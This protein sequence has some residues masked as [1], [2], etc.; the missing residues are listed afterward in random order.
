MK[1][2]DVLRSL[3][4]L[5]H[6]SDAKVVEIADLAGSVTTK[7]EVSSY[8][9]HE[10]EPGFV[11]CPDEFLALF[12]DGLIIHKRG[13]APAGLAKPPLELPVTNNIVLKKL[14]VAFQLKDTDIIELMKPFSQL[15]LSKA[16][17]GAFFRNPTHA[18][19]RECGDQFLRNF[20]K[21]IT[22]GVSK[23]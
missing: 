8:F 23:N 2:N 4:Y 7:S 9:K 20:L 18:N 5:L 12:L 14:R 10:E 16:E 1:T 6:I 15:A 21:A 19:Y 11:V 3:R 13:P 17:V 22:P